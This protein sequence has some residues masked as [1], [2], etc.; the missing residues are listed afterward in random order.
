M[1]TITILI[2]YLIKGITEEICAFTFTVGKVRRMYAVTPYFI[3]RSIP[4]YTAVLQ[5]FNILLAPP[6]CLGVAVP[7]GSSQKASCRFQPSDMKFCAIE[8]NI[9]RIPDEI[10]S[11]GF[12][13]GSVDDVEIMCRCDNLFRQKLCSHANLGSTTVRA[14]QTLH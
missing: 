6:C 9:A 5:L 13:F 3:L 1:A 2:L 10:A 4:K 12:G 7:T 8:N 11:Y 14:S